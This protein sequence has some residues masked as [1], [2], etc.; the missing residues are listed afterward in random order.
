ML[1]EEPG[2]VSWS[3]VGGTF[4]SGVKRLF[5]NDVADTRRFRWQACADKETSIGTEDMWM[6]MRVAGVLAFNGVSILW[7][8]EGVFKQW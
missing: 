1:P 6:W 5:P 4:S 8:S 2:A 7:D 3:E